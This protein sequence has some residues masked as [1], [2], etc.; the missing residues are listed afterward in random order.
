MGLTAI[1]HLVGLSARLRDWEG[2]TN[3]LVTRQCCTN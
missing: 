1:F 2:E 3:A